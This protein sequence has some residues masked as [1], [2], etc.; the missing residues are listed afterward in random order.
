MDEASTSSSQVE[1]GLVDRITE[2][3]RTTIAA[4]VR[5]ALQSSRREFSELATEAC[6]ANLD[7]LAERAAKKA[8][9]ETPEFKGKGT[10]KQYLHNQGVLDEVE[11]ALVAFDTQDVARAKDSLN[12]GKKL[13]LK[14]LKAVR[15]AD[16]EEF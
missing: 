10:K 5:K 7:A 1:E 4:E 16:R 15:I 12:A 14:R 2:R 13:L 3:L 9:L 8:R 11:S 6:S